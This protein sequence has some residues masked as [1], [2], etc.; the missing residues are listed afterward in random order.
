MLLRVSRVMRSSDDRITR[1]TLS[2][3]NPCPSSPSSTI[4]IY[5]YICMC[6]CVCVCVCGGGCVCV[7]QMFLCPSHGTYVH[8][9]IYIYFFNVCDYYS[10]ILQS[11]THLQ[12]QNLFTCQ[13]VRQIIHQIGC[14]VDYV[15]ITNTL[16]PKHW[17]T[18]F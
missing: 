6:V 16:K 10:F 15:N 17:S 9:A 3:N 13:L 18:R 1:E 11:F 8:I 12:K 14:F 7:Y 4:Y 2:N 5:I